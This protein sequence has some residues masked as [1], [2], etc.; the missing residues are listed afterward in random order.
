MKL[1]WL[2]FLAALLIVFMKVPEQQPPLPDCGTAMACVV[3]VPVKS[4]P[5]QAIENRLRWLGVIK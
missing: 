4:A 1:V 5:R 2:A 3:K